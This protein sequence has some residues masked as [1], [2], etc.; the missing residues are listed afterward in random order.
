MIRTR[1]VTVSAAIVAGVALLCTGPASSAPQQPDSIPPALEEAV[2]M[3]FSDCTETA[4]YHYIMTGKIRLL[5]FWIGKD[6]VGDAYVNLGRGSERPGLESIHL[7]IGSD[8]AKAPRSINR[9]GAMTEVIEREQ[10]H[11][12]PARSSASFG[13]MKVTD[14]DTIRSIES[15]L[16]SEHQEGRY[17]FQASINRV[18]RA[19]ARASILPILSP[20]DLDIRQ[21]DEAEQMVLDQY[22][23]RFTSSRYRELRG[24]ART[25]CARNEGFLFTLE[26][27][28]E[29]ALDGQQAPVSLCYLYNTRHYTM[30]LREVKHIDKKRISFDLSQGGEV[31][32]DYSDL[33]ELRLEVDKRLTGKKSKFI[34]LVGTSGELRG[35]PVQA[36]YQPNWWFK[37]VLNL[38][39]VTTATVVPNAQSCALDEAERI[40]S[41]AV[42]NR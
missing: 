28:I 32:R 27:L 5:L 6:D 19:V 8:P 17:P 4:Q 24:N 36:T 34:L 22:A 12:Q 9:W 39:I 25:S 15:E 18:E 40:T 37:A 26:E 1:I 14:G 31:V 11:G 38:H 30:Y 23:D 13:F 29:A 33:L 35:V 7:R 10:V 41:L 2:K 21:M 16:E 42:E 20:T 3:V